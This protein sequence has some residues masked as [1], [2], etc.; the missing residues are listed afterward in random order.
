MDLENLRTAMT[1][2][3][4]QHLLLRCRLLE[5]GNA[6]LIQFTKKNTNVEDIFWGMTLKNNQWTGINMV[7]KILMEIREKLIYYSN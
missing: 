4:E 6:H 7:G 5:T 2:K 3:F 1:L